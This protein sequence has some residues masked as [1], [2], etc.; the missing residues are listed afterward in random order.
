MLILMSF[1]TI[2]NCSAINHKSLQHQNEKKFHR[3]YLI[4]LLLIMA[5]HTL[6]QW[7]RMTELVYQQ[8]ILRMKLKNIISSDGDVLP[9]NVFEC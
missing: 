6:S 2:S 8:R 1:Q 7:C 3:M 9:N 4:P 5:C